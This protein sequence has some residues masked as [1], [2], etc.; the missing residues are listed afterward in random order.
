MAPRSPHETAR[1]ILEACRAGRAAPRA[2]LDSLVDSGSNA[3]FSDLVEP[4]CD[5]FDPALC[6]AYTDLFSHVI[7]RSAPGVVPRTPP[8]GGVD[9]DGVSE[10]WVLSRV[11]LGAD[12]AVTSVLLDAVLKRFPENRV[13]FVGPRKN[14]ELFAAHPR[15]GFVPA[16]YGRRATLAERLAATPRATDPATLVVDPDSRLTQLGLIAPCADSRHLHFPSRSYRPDSSRSLSELA[17]A[18]CRE[19]LGIAD[20]RAFLAPE[21]EPALDRPG[22][23]CVSL[24]T[25]ENP[26]KRLPDPFEQD[27]LRLL[28]RS[29]FEILIDYGAGGEE[30]ERVDRAIAGSGASAGQ[31][32]T[33][34]GS[35]ARF[36]ASIARARLYIGYD[37]SGQH[38]AAASGVPLITV[39][40]GYPNDRFLARWRPH[41]PGRIHVLTARD[42]RPELE[43]ILQTC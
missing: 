14:Y 13:R 43:R 28:V 24:G 5:A 36:A 42:P 12:V 39:F 20:A 38:V 32:H 30:A 3:L 17:S 26:A 8:A 34:N 33:W 18:W 31:V 4:L 29:G 10:V 41:G 9:L 25:G 6:D 40:T 16:S 11:T 21:A 7:R 23:V 19:T 37:S 15:I 2:L 1:A 22:L 35:F 27:L